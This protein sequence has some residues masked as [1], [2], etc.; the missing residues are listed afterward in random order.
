MTEQQPFSIENIR[1]PLYR[2]TLTVLLAEGKAWVENFLPGFALLR[3]PSGDISVLADGSRAINI[4]RLHEL[5]GHVPFTDIVIA[6]DTYLKESLAD[7]CSHVF[8]VSDEGVRALAHTGGPVRSWAILNSAEGSIGE[9]APA[10]W[11]KAQEQV[12]A[13]AKRLRDVVSIS[14]IR[15]NSPA[16]VA[17]C[18]TIG[19]IFLLQ[20]AFNSL[21]RMPTL[22]AMGALSPH[23]L[24]LGEYWR[25]LSYAFL[26]GSMLHF[27]MNTYVLWQ[28]GKQLENFTGSSR[29][30][31]IYTAAT[32]AAGV[33]SGL[34]LGDRISVGASGGIWGLLG[35]H[36][37]LFWR[38]RNFLPP[39]SR[40]RMERGLIMTFGLNI[41]ISFL[42]QVDMAAHFG[43]GIAGALMAHILLAKNPKTGP[44]VFQ[45]D[46]A[47]RLMPMSIVFLAVGALSGLL[48]GQPWK[49][50]EA[51]AYAS[52][53][54][55]KITLPMPTDLPE[56]SPDGDHRIFGDFRRTTM[57]I[58]VISDAPDEALPEP[59]QAKLSNWE[60]QKSLANKH[61]AP[62]KAFKS[63]NSQTIEETNRHIIIT[64]GKV[65]DG[66]R[67]DFA[68][69]L[70]REPGGEILITRID[71]AYHPSYPHLN[72]IARTIA[73]GCKLTN[74][75]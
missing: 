39:D 5:A 44:S 14:P 13:S 67:Y 19:A 20:L 29:F 24:Q 66:M 68:V 33:A 65:D 38:M 48:F 62:P 53:S 36:A 26:H 8:V 22:I 34:T 35:A 50:D 28:I 18:L 59:S 3:Y 45:L 30:L 42:P 16:T 69:I 43:G 11:R 1:P 2:D 51:P 58:T 40:K 21:D 47:R 64:E 25:I 54:F 63:I 37:I 27:G 73:L 15:R 75:V 49:L 23:H 4:E 56:E 32:I 61:M 74:K 71:V 60:L 12:E 70:N 72:N 6:D 10:L 17:I 57:V 52:Q 46:F 9:R 31:V 7:L 41:G 55:E